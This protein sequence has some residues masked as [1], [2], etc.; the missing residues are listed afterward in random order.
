M[1]TQLVEL[2]IEDE[3]KENYEELLTLNTMKKII[4]KNKRLYGLPC[5]IPD[6]WIMN[7]SVEELNE[8]MV[9]ARLALVA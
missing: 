2:F 7:A 1:S 8:R 9:G 6:E 5:D 4:T 3:G